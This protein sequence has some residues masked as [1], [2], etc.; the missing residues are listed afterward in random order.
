MVVEEFFFLISI[1]INIYGKLHKTGSEL[2]TSDELCAK[3]D[4]S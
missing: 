4:F 2:N 1:K 3:L